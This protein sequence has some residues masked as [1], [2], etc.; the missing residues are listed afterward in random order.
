M[1][2]NAILFPSA[3]INGVHEMVG[4]TPNVNNYV[5]ENKMLPQRKINQ[6]KCKWHRRNKKKPKFNCYNNECTNF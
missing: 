2:P 4:D 5:S 1:F 6:P 3:A